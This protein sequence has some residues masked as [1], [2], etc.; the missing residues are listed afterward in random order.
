MS[1]SEHIK[2][3]NAGLD[4]LANLLRAAAGGWATLLSIF[5]FHEQH[6]DEDETSRDLAG[7]TEPRW[8]SE[9]LELVEA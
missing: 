3:D 7:R 1:K 9:R 4:A 6:H 5:A 2:D 8:W